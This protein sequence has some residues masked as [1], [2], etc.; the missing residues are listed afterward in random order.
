MDLP[1]D[2][3]NEPYRPTMTCIDWPE[4]IKDVC[5]CEGMYNVYSQ[6]HECRTHL[7]CFVMHKMSPSMRLPLKGHPQPIMHIHRI[8]S[9]VWFSLQ[10]NGECTM[11]AQWQPRWIGT[12]MT[13]YIH[14]LSCTNGEGK[15]IYHIHCV[16]AIMVVNTFLS[17][18]TL[19]G[20]VIRVLV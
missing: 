3:N 20:S 15:V 12:T 10:V 19:D 13:W 17:H 14:T 16:L 4:H 6:S 18:V 7:I 5:C 2:V 9:C 8:H 1:K 11:Q